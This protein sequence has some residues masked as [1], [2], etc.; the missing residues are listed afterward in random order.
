MTKIVSPPLHRQ[1]VQGTLVV[2]PSMASI[3]AAAEA[4]DELVE[5]D[6]TELSWDVD[7][8]MEQALGVCHSQLRLSSGE[9]SQ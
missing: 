9:I 1:F 3:P 4:A 6:L 5:D 8:D 7:A 2:S